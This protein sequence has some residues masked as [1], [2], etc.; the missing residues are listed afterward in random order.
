MKK[1]KRLIAKIFN[2]DEVVMTIDRNMLSCEFGAL[3]RGNLTDV[4]NWGIYANRGSIS[5]IDNIGY[6]NNK[7]VNST[8]IKKCLVKFYLA[9]NQE[10]LIATFKIDNV[11]FD[12]ETRRVDIQLIGKIIELQNKPSTLTGKDVFTF[13]VKQAHYLLGLD[14]S[15]I[16]ENYN[17][18]YPSYGLTIGEDNEQIYGARIWCP[19]ITSGAF[20]DK[21]TKIC[22]ATMCRVVEDENGNP[23]ITGERPKKTTIIVNPKNIISISKSDFVKVTNPS[24]EILLRNRYE[25]KKVESEDKSFSINYDSSIKPLSVSGADSSFEY[26]KN[27]IPSLGGIPYTNEGWIADVTFRGKL[28]NKTRRISSISKITTSEILNYSDNTTKNY[29]KESEASWAEVY[30]ENYENLYISFLSEILS[31]GQFPLGDGSSV[32][33]RRKITSIDYSFYLDYFEDEGWDTLTKINDESEKNTEKID[34]NDFIQKNGYTTDNGVIVGIGEHILNEVV[35]RYGKGRECF[36][37]ECLFNDY[38]DENGNKAFDT[39]DLSNH[40]EKYDI[41]IPYVNKKGKP[42]PLRVNEDGTPKKFRI[43]G[44]SYSYDGLL[45]QKLSVQEERYDVD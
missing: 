23:I 26:F 33:E 22:Q 42:V 16:P 4:V 2:G 7:N 31:D 24:L 34:S 10:T 43:I 9:K 14:S 38:Y 1:N 13:D 11:D 21:T 36:E 3:D 40:F 5:F 8:D 30:I 37:I 29:S 19:Y 32:V 12:D 20:W 18:E 44:I 41:I 25:K 17:E 27:E 45:K 39:N 6:F 28:S 35:R 15:N